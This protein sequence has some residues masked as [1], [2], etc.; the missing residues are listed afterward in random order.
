MLLANSKIYPPPVVKSAVG[1]LSASESE[2]ADPRRRR[3]RQKTYTSLVLQPPLE[4]GTVLLLEEERQPRAAR[5]DDAVSESRQPRLSGEGL[6]H[7]D[8]ELLAWNTHTFDAD[9]PL[10]KQVINLEARDSGHR[11]NNY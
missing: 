6:A 11:L 1:G 3:D 10:Q 8:D 2:Q 9:P 7:E 5:L 4:E